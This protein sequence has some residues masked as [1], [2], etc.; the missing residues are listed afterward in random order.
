MVRRAERAAARRLNL[1]HNQAAPLN[2]LQSSGTADEA[3]SAS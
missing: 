1:P 3:S 2:P